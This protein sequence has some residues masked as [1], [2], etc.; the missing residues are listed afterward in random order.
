LHAQSLIAEIDGKDSTGQSR[1]DVPT[2]FGTNSQTLSVTQ[3][4]TVATGGGY[5]DAR[6]LHRCRSPA[7]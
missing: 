3:K 2:L 7:R 5:L 1:T 6:V 4:A